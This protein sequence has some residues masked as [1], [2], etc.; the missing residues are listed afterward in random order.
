MGIEIF[1]DTDGM[2]D[3]G[4]VDVVVGIDIDTPH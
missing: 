2:P 3:D 1:C 4:G